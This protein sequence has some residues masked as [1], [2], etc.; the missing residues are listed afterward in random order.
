MKKLLAFLALLFASFVLAQPAKVLVCAPGNLA[1]AKFTD[2]ILAKFYFDPID[3]SDTITDA[4][5]NYEAV[6]L[7]L[8]DS[9]ELTLEKGNLLKSFLKSNKK[10]Y[11]EYGLS[12]FELHPWDTSG[13]WKS[14]GV[15]NV[16]EKS[17]E[18]PIRYVEGVKGTFTEGLYV[19]NSNYSPG[20][21]DVPSVLDLVGTVSQALNTEWPLYLAYTH[22]S[23]SFKVV[24]HW[25]TIPDYYEP[26]LHRVICNYFGLC[27]PAS[28]KQTETTAAKISLFPNP[29]QDVLHIRSN[30]DN[31]GLQSVEL[32]SETGLLISKFSIDPNENQFDL[33][34]G[35]LNITNG[36]YF[37]NIEMPKESFLKKIF[38]VK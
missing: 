24:L 8:P 28:V 13:F 37:L 12:S 23:D 33:D 34:L 29:A 25:R 31:S 21:M 32:I 19:A 6:F 2:S 15:A 10:L 38:L 16:R 1:A 7:L 5:N 14:I 4:I 22:E 36:N 11:V 30:M 35:K 3:V 20:T 27:T 9:R 17:I 26:F 18:A